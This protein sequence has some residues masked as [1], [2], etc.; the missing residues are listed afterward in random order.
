MRR[1]VALIS[2]GKDS[3]YSLHLALWQGFD[4][5]A[6]G[7]AVPPPDSMV[8]QHENVRFAEVH[9]RALGLPTIFSEAGAGEDSE[10]AAIHDILHT[11]RS[12]YCADWAVV[13][14]LSS[15]YQRMRFNYPAKDLGLKV[16]TP[17][18]HVNPHNYLK[19][20][21]RDGFEFII[22]RVAAEGLDRSW[23]GRG[24][25]K[26]NLD[27]LFSLAD[28]HSFNPVGEGGEYESFVVKTPLYGVDVR[29]AVKGNSFII[30]EVELHDTC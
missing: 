21:I 22:T 4:V 24:I 18:W 13:G 19:N 12:K 1:A 2:G 15:D 3:I 27:D 16:H 30:N 5:S 14:A 6:V 28:R 8:V 9:A 29:G 11:A 23:L 26:E 10:I 20:L 7:I 25:T 17:L